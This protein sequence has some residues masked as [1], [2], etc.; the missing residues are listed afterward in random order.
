[1][2][3]SFFLVE[4]GIK[5]IVMGF[6]VARSVTTIWFS[7]ALMDFTVAANCGKLPKTIFS[8]EISVPSGLLFPSTWTSSPGFKSENELALASE[9]FAESGE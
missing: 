3:G 5:R 7:A 8:A 4:S 9:S 6:F 1:M 2:A